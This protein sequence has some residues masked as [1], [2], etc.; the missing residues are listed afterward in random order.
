MRYAGAIL[1]MAAC[2]LSGFIAA[3]RTAKRV[4]SLGGI[5]AFL[6]LYVVELGCSMSCTDE[7][8]RSTAGISGAP[9]FVERYGRLSDEGMSLPEAWKRAV[10][11]SRDRMCLE[12]EETRIIAELGEIFGRYDVQGQIRAI[13]SRTAQLETLLS[14]ADRCREQKT[15]VYRTLGVLA[16]AAAAIVIC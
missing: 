12:R 13:E 6:K 3:G 5:I 14:R 2:A 15:P 11:E 10:A 4:S 1:I 9:C 8:I 16:G 7:L